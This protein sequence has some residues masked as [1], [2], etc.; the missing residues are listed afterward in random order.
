MS[1]ASKGSILIVDDD[2]ALREAMTFDFSRRGYQVSSASSGNRALDG[3]SRSPV[4]L[5][6]SDVR[7]PDGDGIQLLHRVRQ[8]HYELPLLIF[9]TGYADLSLEEAYDQG[10]DAVFGKPF[11]RAELFAA[12]L[13]ALQ[14]RQERWKL[15]AL[16][17]P[18]PLLDLRFSTLEAA[19][20]DGAFSLGR[21]GFFAAQNSPLPWRAGQRLR[22]KIAF[23]G[24]PERSLQGSG[25]ARWVRGQGGEGRPS[26]LGV[27]F[28][29]LEASGREAFESYISSRRIVAF[30]PSG[31]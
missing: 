23:E 8:L 3:L 25:I 17:E 30:I 14:P 19:L 22:F 16:P 4:D 27:E 12:V 15:Q 20:V 11:D 31:T 9:I 26:G 5:I 28:V 18:E 10:A 24:Q 1:E 13:R 7:M 21:G 2:D 29:H 6:L